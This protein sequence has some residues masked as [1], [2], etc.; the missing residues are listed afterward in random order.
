MHESIFSMITY[1][2]GGWTWS[3]LYTMPIHLRQFYLN[4]MAEMKLEERKAMEQPHG[5]S[6]IDMPSAV[7]K[8]LGNIPT[9]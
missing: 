6:S 8:A 7:K 2:K 5:V 4:K 3:D 9:R 1:G